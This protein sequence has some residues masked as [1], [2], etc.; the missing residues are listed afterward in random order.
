VGALVF[1]AAFQQDATETPGGLNGQFPGSLLVPDNLVARPY[2]GGTDIYVRADRFGDVYAADVDPATVAVM[3][4]A[5]HPFDP[6]SLDGSFAGTATWRT[7]PSWSVVATE[8]R[9]IPTETLRF[10]AKRAGSTVVEVNSAHAVPVAHP[11]IV[12]DTIAAAIASLD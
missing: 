5:Q 9:S 1:V 4:A 12:A 3:A 11:Q 8:D 10:M 7:L 2:P 6:V